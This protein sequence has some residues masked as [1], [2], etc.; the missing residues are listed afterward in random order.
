M[1]IVSCCGGDCN[2]LLAFL[3]GSTAAKPSDLVA[4]ASDASTSCSGGSCVVVVEVVEVLVEEVDGETEEDPLPPPPP[5]P[6]PPAVLVRP[7][8]MEMEP[9]NGG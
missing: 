7:A 6:P 4:M 2:W 5:P 8:W 3:E 1:A 9:M